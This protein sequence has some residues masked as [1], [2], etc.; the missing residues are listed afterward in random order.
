MPPNQTLVPPVPM[1][2]PVLPCKET[3]IAY[4]TCIQ[5]QIQTCW[6]GILVDRRV[7]TVWSLHYNIYNKHNKGNI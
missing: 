1:M 3:F 5:S 4:I 6:V 2:T 7:P